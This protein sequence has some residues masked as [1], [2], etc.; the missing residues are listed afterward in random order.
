MKK[1]I[2]LFFFALQIVA[3]YAQDADSLPQR[4]L[5]PIDSLLSKIKPDTS[6]IEIPDSLKVDTVYID[7]P[8]NVLKVGLNL[9]S[10]YGMIGITYERVLWFSG[11]AQLKADFIGKYSPFGSMSFIKDAYDNTIKISGVGLTPEFRYYGTEKYAPLGL[12]AGCYLPLIFATVEAPLALDYEGQIYTLPKTN[13]NYSLIGIGFDVGY[14][15]VFK[16]KIALEG[17]VGL[18]IAKGTFSE[19]FY[20]QKY[21]DQYGYEYENKL[22]LRDGS[23]GNAFYPRFEINV[24]WAF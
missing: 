7:N 16:K 17:L 12:F 5:V 3:L 2:L 11:T 4:K 15:W 1:V 9:P 18:G 24:G 6:K 10:A 13:L 20:T 8:M 23:I 22:P 14:Q 19:R 21:V